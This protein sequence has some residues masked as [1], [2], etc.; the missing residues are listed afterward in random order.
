M[1]ILVDTNFLLDLMI[2]DRANSSSSIRVIDA[3]NDGAVSIVLCAGSLNDAYYVARNFC[4]EDGRRGWLS[5]FLD[6]FDVVPVNAALCRRSLASDEPDFED[7][8]V[9]ACAELVGADYIVSTDRK[10]FRRSSVLRIESPELAQ[11]LGY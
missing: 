11:R 7:G 5:F 8:L 10:A 3:F 1:K 9:R 6:R 4:T 2:P